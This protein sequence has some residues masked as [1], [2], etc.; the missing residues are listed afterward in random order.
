MDLE[1][2]GTHQQFAGQSTGNGGKLLNF[3]DG[4]ELN[5]ELPHIYPPK[6]IQILFYRV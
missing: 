1:P 2:I 3:P 6:G 4:P 5:C